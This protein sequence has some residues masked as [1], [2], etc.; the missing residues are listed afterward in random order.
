M[1]KS[2][3]Y[4]RMT[5]TTTITGMVIFNDDTSTILGFIWK[6]RVSLR[7]FGYLEDEQ[8]QNIDI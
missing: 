3:V 2:L 1:K 4:I 6:R 8:D 7:Y 5:T